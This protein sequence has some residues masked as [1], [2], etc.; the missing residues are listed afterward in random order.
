MKLVEKIEFELKQLSNSKKGK[1]LYQFF[2]AFP[3]GYGEGDQF[4]GVT[5]PLQR[6]VSKKYYREITLKEIENLLTDPVHE[7][8]LTALFM[9]ILKFQQM[10]DKTECEK[11]VELYLKKIK[12]VNNWDLVDSSAHL[13]LGPWLFERDR[14]ILYE[15]A[16]SKNLWVQRI[17]VLTT[18]HFIRNNQ[19]KDT[20][21]LAETLLNHKHDL[22]H[23]AVGWMLREIGNRD[24]DTEYGFLVKHYKMMP[25]TM[26]RYSIEK[27]P[28]DVRQAFLKSEI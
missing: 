24:Y 9:L 27:F 20:L 21:R 14:K 3:G 22:I 13:I 12:H 11:I 16:D 4:L 6:A 26:L 25:R 17:A 23:K 5:V 2:Q 19:Y 15:F 8:R 1:D 28:E 18:Y 10:K 7:H